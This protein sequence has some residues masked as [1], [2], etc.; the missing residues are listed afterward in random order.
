MNNLALDRV[1][2]IAAAVADTLAREEFF[3]L[4]LKGDMGA[5]KTTFVRLF[6]EELGLD[7]SIQVTSPTFTYLNPYYIADRRFA[8]IDLYR[9]P[10]IAT[11]VLI[12]EDYDGFL[13]EWPQTHLQ[14]LRPTHQLSITKE[15]VSSRSYLFEVAVEV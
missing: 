11:E 14:A 10:N 8:H 15:S 12:L 5:G 7:T 1:S 13:V 9:S 2:T 3:C 4:W 6:F